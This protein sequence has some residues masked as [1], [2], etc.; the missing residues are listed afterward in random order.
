MGTMCEFVFGLASLRPNHTPKVFLFAL[1]SISATL[2]LGCEKQASSRTQPTNSVSTVISP[3]SVDG[4]NAVAV[5][6]GMQ[7]S[8]LDDTNVLRSFLA[9]GLVRNVPADGQTLVVRHEDIPGFMPKMTMAFN[10][11]DANE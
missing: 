7:A 2:L 3:P 10:V 11:R 8:P 9:R 5:S 4:T 6:P 1:A